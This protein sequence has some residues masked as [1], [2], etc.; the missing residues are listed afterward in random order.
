[1]VSDTG[2]YRPRLMPSVL[3][4]VSETGMP[5]TGADLDSQLISS[6][7]NV[8]VCSAACSSDKSACRALPNRTFAN[9]IADDPGQAVDPPS[10]F[11]AALRHVPFRT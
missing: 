2:K 6:K 10:L 11:G 5:A 4:R 1:M 9:L 7:W 3:V 8:G